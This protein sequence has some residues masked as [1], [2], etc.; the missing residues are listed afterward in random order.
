MAVSTQKEIGFKQALSQG[1]WQASYFDIRRPALYETQLA[2][3][4]T[5]AQL[6]P[7]NPTDC[8][9]QSFDGDAHH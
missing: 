8:R 3:S 9:I 2:G 5:A 1:A 7:N 6:C 4:S